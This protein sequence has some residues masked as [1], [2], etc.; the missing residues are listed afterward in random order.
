MRRI[1][2]W[3][4]RDL[5]D[6]LRSLPPGRYLIEEYTGQPLDVAPEEDDALRQLAA[7]EASRHG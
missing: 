3:N 5:P 7:Y 1:V 4:G 6:E 2:E